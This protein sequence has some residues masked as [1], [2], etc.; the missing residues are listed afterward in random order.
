MCLRELF[1]YITELQFKGMHGQKDFPKREKKGNHQ[2]DKTG[3]KDQFTEQLAA[4]KQGDQYL[5]GARV[6][7]QIMVQDQPV[8]DALHEAFKADQDPVGICRAS[9]C[10]RTVAP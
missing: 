7:G 4:C 5:N 10:R 3:G 9:Q 2:Q 6:A 8:G 1:L